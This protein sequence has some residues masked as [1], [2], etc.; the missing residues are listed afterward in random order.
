MGYF[1][2]ILLSAS[3]A[4][5]VMLFFLVQISNIEKYAT[6]WIYNLLKAGLIFLTV[7]LIVLIIFFV[8]SLTKVSMIRSYQSDFLLY[9][10]YIFFTY[11]N[12]N[13]S[14]F[15]IIFFVWILGVL[16][17]GTR[18]FFDVIHFYKYK[19]ENSDQV[20][21]PQILQIIQKIKD[22]L[23]ISKDILVYYS[24]MNTV[25]SIVIINRPII[26][27]GST[28][29]TSQEFL[30][31][32]KHELI[33]LKRNHILF[34][35]IGII[36]QIVYWFNPLLDNFIQFFCEYCELDCDREV[37][38]NENMRQRLA[39]ANTLL[40]LI[41]HNIPHN[42]MI[43]SNFSWMRNSTS[44]ERRFENIMNNCPKKNINK[45]VAIL[46]ICYLLCCPL[47][48]YGAVAGGLK[49]HSQYVK[50]TL[51]KH[52]D[53]AE[54]SALANSD[55][56]GTRTVINEYNLDNRGKNTIDDY[57]ATDESIVIT[58]TALSSSIRVNI[59][60]DSGSDEF[61]VGIGD[62]YVT[63]SSG[64]ISYTFDT[65]PNKQYKIY[66]DNLSN[67]KIH[68]SGNIYV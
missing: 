46:T 49:A 29:L 63:S 21:D 45:K 4:T 9:Y 68:I 32:I 58:V 65:V 24:K 14:Y 67:R 31:T 19:I 64:M 17:K 51:L 1:L 41:P 37:L 2:L 48:T 8:Y 55:Y 50:N 40:K 26:F 39:Y 27:I 36:T 60:S 59:S 43:E 12:L 16:F 10:K 47:V 11:Q 6:T 44:L 56:I 5:G 34:K 25:P 62:D 20:V 35:R 15:W 33:H 13:K 30:Y 66:I 18:M 52:S 23:G 53:Q 22:E 54:L 38:K 3:L 42:P 28:E 57:L 61:G 7:P